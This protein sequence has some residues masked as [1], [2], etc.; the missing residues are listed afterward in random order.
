MC[1]FVLC[2]YNESRGFRA[3]AKNLWRFLED[4]V[5]A[6]GINHSHDNKVNTTDVPPVLSLLI[7]SSLFFCKSH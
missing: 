1:V 4:G 3:F 5:G 6:N 7:C 2:V